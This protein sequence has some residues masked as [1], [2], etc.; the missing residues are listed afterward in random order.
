MKIKHAPIYLIP[1]AE[2]MSGC[3]RGPHAILSYRNGLGLWSGNIAE[4]PAYHDAAST[5]IETARL[6]AGKDQFVVLGG[7]HSASA[8]VVRSLSNT[9]GKIHLVVFDAH[10]DEYI[11]TRQ[12]LDCG[13]WIRI[14]KDCFSGITRFGC[15]DKKAYSEKVSTTNRIHI[16]VDLDVLDAKEYGFAANFPERNGMKLE[17]LCEKI[18]AVAKKTTSPIT[19]DIS[20]YNPTLDVTGAGVY[21]ANQILSVLHDIV[22][23]QITIGA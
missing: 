19:A 4:L 7:D 16:S 6:L 8:G 14:E 12:S 20:E 22:S 15:R 3:R 18:I 1:Y 21:C 9:F 23:E 2:G 11:T 13:N 10:T 5:A 17:E